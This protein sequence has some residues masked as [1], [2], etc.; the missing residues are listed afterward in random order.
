[1]YRLR[2]RRAGPDAMPIILP[3]NQPTAGYTSIEFV[4]AVMSLD[5][6]PKIDLQQLESAERERIGQGGSFRVEKAFIDGDQRQLPLAVVIKHPLHKPNGATHN[7]NWNDILLEIQ[8]LLHPPIAACRNVVDLL[9]IGWEAETAEHIQPMLVMPYATFGTLDAYIRNHDPTVSSKIAMSFD[10]ASALDVLHKCGIVHGDLKS[11]NVLVFFEDQRPIAKLSDFGCSVINPQS[12]RKIAAGTPPWNCP[13]W[14]DVIAKENLPQT[15]VYSFGLLFWRVLSKGPN[16]FRS[17]ESFSEGSELTETLVEKLKSSKDDKFLEEANKSLQ[18]DDPL[19]KRFQLLEEILGNSIRHDPSKRNLHRC[20]RSLKVILNLESPSAISQCGRES[21]EGEV[22]VKPYL[23]ELEEKV[24]I[25]A[26]SRLPWTLQQRLFKH[27]LAVSN[28]PENQLNTKQRMA[29]SRW[30]FLYYLLGIGMD[31][32]DELACHHLLT[33]ARCG[34]PVAKS[35][36]YRAII[37][38]RTS[39]TFESVDLVTIGQWL[40][41][42]LELGYWG[43]KEDFAHLYASNENQ[44]ERILKW[45]GIALDRLCCY[46]A[47]VGKEYFL[48][49]QGNRLN[50]FGIESQADFERRVREKQREGE[51]DVNAFSV[52]SRGDGLLHLA[53]TCG[54]EDATTF[55]IQHF[56]QVLDIN[57]TN[58]NGE[59]SL[60][61]ASRAGQS[62]TVLI[63]LKNGADLRPSN[64][65]ESPLHWLGAFKTGFSELGS[66]MLLSTAKEGGSEHEAKMCHLHQKASGTAYSEYW[67]SRLPGGTPLHRAVHFKIPAVVETLL[68]LGADPHEPG[69]E[70]NPESALQLACIRHYAD[71]V[72][73]LLDYMNISDVGQLESI[74][75]LHTALSRNSKIVSLVDSGVRSIGSEDLRST[76]DVLIRRKANPGPLSY[77]LDGKSTR[78]TALFQAVESDSLRCVELALSKSLLT[79]KT[80]LNMPC[81]IPARTPLNVAVENGSLEIV[82]ALLEAGADPTNPIGENNTSAEISVLHS[83]ALADFSV[84]PDTLLRI[85]NLL[86]PRFKSV[87]LQA[88]NYE[89]LTDVLESPFVLAVRLGRFDLASSLLCRG[90]DIDFLFAKT[91]SESNESGNTNL[92]S[93]DLMTR[94]HDGHHNYSQITILGALLTIPS[95]STNSITKFLLGYDDEGRK[96]KDWQHKLPSV[97][98]SKHTNWTIWHAVAYRRTRVPLYDMEHVKELTR[99]LSENYQHLGKEF[100][101]K[102]CGNGSPSDSKKTALH[103]AVECTNPEV[104][105]ALLRLGADR[106]ATDSDGYRPIDYASSILQEEID[107]EEELGWDEVATRREIQRRKDIYIMLGGDMSVFECSDGEDLESNIQVVLEID[108][109]REDPTT[110]ACVVPDSVSRP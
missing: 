104:V 99:L 27:H 17:L 101:N 100:L 90:A 50:P 31:E 86:A 72:E 30:L 67:S 64:T 14:R 33:A 9:A 84:K 83:C 4:S 58:Y 47:G 56:G 105:A 97:V 80:F 25:Q 28:A 13:E 68:R 1:M 44:A 7:L 87:D 53:A 82:E 81:G 69:V 19:S 18:T 91:V 70:K 23:F 38:L 41:R 32:N 78:I 39:S 88:A 20:L 71:I 65:G 54:F 3:P 2:R 37:A 107:I 51:F 12:F 45:F 108:P 43:A 5:Y 74:P 95:P 94:D 85:F 42:N 109:S 49:A 61:S 102:R 29:S 55:L 106:E 60:L 93:F 10:V 8:A 73:I 59:T 48:D 35:L 63:L 21:I 110:Q 52:N 103:V 16:P 76:V 6:Q 92:K 11:E 62:N 36:S 26:V 66:L 24:D 46:M 40:G 89:G 15:D 22:D 79:S 34:D 57:V 98:V 77:V 96:K 75:L